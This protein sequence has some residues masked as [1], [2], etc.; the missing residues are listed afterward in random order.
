MLVE[1]ANR[2][3]RFHYILHR[4]LSVDE[5]L[6]GTKS[7]TAIT[8]YLP[9]KHHHSWGIKLLMKCDSVTNYCLGFFPKKGIKGNST[10]GSNEGANPGSGYKV[11]VKLLKI[12]QYL[13]K[14]YHVFHWQS[15]YFLKR[16]T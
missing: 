8:Q 2:V 3:F 12:G 10:T 13:N 16:H 9:K 1:H 6:V 11:V 14:G 5:S 15:I 7:H 4:E